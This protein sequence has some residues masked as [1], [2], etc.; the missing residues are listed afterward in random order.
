MKIAVATSQ[1]PA[2]A[3]GPSG[4]WRYLRSVGGIRGERSAQPPEAS[5]TFCLPA[6]MN[7]IIERSSAPT[8]SI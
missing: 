2:L 7:G 4:R 1:A 3:N 5:W 6:E 8:F